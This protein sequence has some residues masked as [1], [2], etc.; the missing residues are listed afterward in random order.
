M[1]NEANAGAVPQQGAG[2]VAQSTDTQRDGQQAGATSK[3]LSQEEVNRIVEERLARER[4]KYA[5]Y[6]ELRKAKAE[7]DR[8]RQ[9][10][11]SETERL[12]ALASEK[13]RQA[14]LLE[15]QLAQLA[16]RADFVEKAL[17]AGVTDIRLAY[18]AAQAEGLLGAYDPEKG[19]SE[20]NFAEL[21]KRYPHLFRPSTPGSAEGGAGGGRIAGTSMNDWI[22]R[23]A[24]R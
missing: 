20:H 14:I 18:L 10:Q 22:R 6:E 4:Q 1:P 24:G 8:I 2:D 11:M 13:E 7:L 21:K 5:D 12:Q 17:G 19:V 3:M 23:V 16:V 15:T 9:S